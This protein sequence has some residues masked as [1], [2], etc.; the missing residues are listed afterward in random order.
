MRVLLDVSAVPER[1]VGAGVYTI[2]LAVEL[3][4]SG[5][6]ELHLAARRGDAPRW[7]ER[8]PSATCHPVVRRPAPP[9]WHGAD[10]NP[11]LARRIGPDGLARPPLHDAP[12]ARC[13]PWSRSTT[14]GLRPPR[15]ARAVE[16]VFFRRMIRPRPEGRGCSP[17]ATGRPGPGGA[18]PPHTIPVGG[19]LGVTTPASTP[20]PP[21][22]GPGCAGRRGGARTSPSPGRRAPQGHPHPRGGVRDVGPVEARP[23][24]GAGGPRRLGHRGA[25]VRRRAQ[26]RGEPG[27][28]HRVV[29]RRRPPGAAAPGRGRRVPVAGGGLRAARPGGPRLRRRARDHGRL[30]DG[31]PGRARG[32]DRPRQR[33]RSPGRRPRSGPR[34]SRPVVGPAR[35]RGGA[36][37]PLHLGGVHGGPPRRVSSGGR[38]DRRRR[39]RREGATDEQSDHGAGARTRPRGGR[40]EGRGDRFE[41]VRGPATSSRRSEP[42]AT[43]SRAST[44]AP[45]GRRRHRW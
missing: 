22:T 38:G 4:A 43:P 23:A 18:P 40:D 9:A 44:S 14:D 36:C 21:T 30:G 17:T 10:R 32:R 16:G 15:V 5:Q 28:A 29:P 13:P 19:P 42:A 12:G 41:A 1:P 45:E 25:P 39:D 33:R 24:V 3:A 2:N 20:T 35:G 27:A 11:V 34:R 26:P 8:C 6:V 37:L 7:N 31:R